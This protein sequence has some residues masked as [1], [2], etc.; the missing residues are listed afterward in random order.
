MLQHKNVSDAL[1]VDHLLTK[2]CY[3]ASGSAE[4][5]GHAGPG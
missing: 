4:D 1:C 2:E 3:V 5:T